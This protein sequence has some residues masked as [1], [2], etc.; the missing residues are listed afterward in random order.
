MYTSQIPQPTSHGSHWAE[1][2]RGKGRNDEEAGLRH[3]GTPDS[4]GLK[5]DPTAAHKRSPQ[6]KTQDRWEAGGLQKVSKASAGAG[7]EPAGSLTGI[8][9]GNECWKVGHEAT[10]NLVCV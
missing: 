6:T 3:Q 10:N 8:Q 4:D 1:W 9:S 5:L 2:T 7:I